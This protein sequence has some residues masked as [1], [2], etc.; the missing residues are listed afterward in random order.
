MK[1]AIH[2]DL[3]TEFGYGFPKGF[4]SNRDFD[5]LVLAGDFSNID[6]LDQY[7]GQVRQINP[8]KP[9][10][11]VPGNHD[12]YAKKTK[13]GVALELM[14]DVCTQNVVSFLYR[15]TVHFAE[16]KTTFSG[17]VGWPN[18]KSVQGY[19][20]E[21]DKIVVKKS[22]SDFR[23]IKGWSMDKMLEEAD[24]D[25]QFL[26][27]MTTHRPVADTHVMITHFPPSLLLQN[28]N[29]PINPLT[30]YFHNDYPEFF[31]TENKPDVWIYGHTHFGV[32]KDIN[33]V[34]CFSNQLGY[35]G[36]EAGYNPNL[37]VE[38]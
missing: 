1:I 10:I 32:N 21:W 29:F 35:E 16:F 20:D 6:V 5:V 23:W 34:K 13:F 22:I 2:S 3:H 25:Y 24:K 26:R 11:F 38:V 33:G 27:L 7:L 28:P 17:C 14:E 36:E 9:I 30:N 19:V 4:L 8:D 37:T 18:M 31:E 15:N 12:F